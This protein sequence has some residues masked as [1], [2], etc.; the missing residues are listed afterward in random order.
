MYNSAQDTDE[1]TLTQ[2]TPKLADNNNNQAEVFF[3][4][5][6]FTW[7]VAWSLI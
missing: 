3:G 5:F 4:S 1:K 2:S 7:G 6:I